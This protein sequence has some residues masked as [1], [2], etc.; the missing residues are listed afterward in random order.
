[1]DAS[2]HVWSQIRNVMVYW[3][4]AEEDVNNF[5]SIWKAI[6]VLYKA[7]QESDHTLF[8]GVDDKIEFAK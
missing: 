2:D 4:E 5:P 3:Q 8:S 7:E 1:M 6:N